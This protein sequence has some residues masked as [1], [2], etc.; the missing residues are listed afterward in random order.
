MFSPPKKSQSVRPVAVT[1]LGLRCAQQRFPSF[2]LM[3]LLINLQAIR[4]HMRSFLHAV[5]K[6]Q[7][8]MMTPNTLGRSGV[9]KSFIK[10]TTPL[11]TD[12]KV[13]HLVIWV[14]FCRRVLQGSSRENTLNEETKQSGFGRAVVTQSSL[15]ILSP[16]VERWCRGKCIIDAVR[17][18]VLHCFVVQL[19]FN[20]PLSNVINE[21]IY[22]NY[23]KN[24]MFQYHFM[25]LLKGELF[26]RTLTTALMMSRLLIPVFR[27][28][29]V[30]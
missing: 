24:T 15:W 5:Q 27:L 18:W 14:C 20:K 9:M 4:P 13:C 2:S 11:R 29:L 16:T 22:P 3:V 30:K 25:S 19:L 1:V 21:V 10:H 8:L 7:M 17:L 26:L 23:N 6:N 28:A 12:P